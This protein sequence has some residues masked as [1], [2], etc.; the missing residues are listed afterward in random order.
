M[1][2]DAKVKCNCYRDN[3]LSSPPPYAEF[4]KEDDWGLELDLDY[5]SNKKA[6]QEFE[7]W[8][9]SNPC[10]HEGFDMY[11]AR[12][13]NLSGMSAILTM[14]SEIGGDERYPML[15]EYM[16]VHDNEIPA[17]D[18][19]KLLAEVNRFKTERSTE[20]KVC[21][22]N[23][24]QNEFIH[25]VNINAVINMIYTEFYTA[26]LSENGFSITQK[27]FDGIIMT[28]ETETV[29]SSKAFT[30]TKTENGFLLTDLATN[31]TFEWH[32]NISYQAHDLNELTF[33]VTTRKTTVA[34]EYAYLMEV[35]TNLAN[36]SMETGNP[37]MFF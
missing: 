1:G 10:E 25:E 26:T 23:T 15:H 32:M 33:E 8:L 36:A 16:G 12:L 22:V 18:A 31:N 17:S 30:Q 6:F 20:A 3:K 11:Y 5:R 7:A 21:L 9:D 29:F 13:G 24:T 28:E 34:E 35:L 27:L 37:I 4:V 2:F 19:P 14:L